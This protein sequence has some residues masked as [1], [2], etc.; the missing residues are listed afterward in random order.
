MTLPDHPELSIL[1]VVDSDALSAFIPALATLLRREFSAQVKLEVVSNGSGSDAAPLATLLSLEKMIVRRNRPCWA[2]RIAKADIHD[3]LETRSNQSFS[4]VIDLTKGT[5]KHAQ[6]V[7]RPLYNG[8][9]GEPAL[10]SSLLFLG[11][12]KISISVQREAS[13]QPAIICGGTASLESA[14]GIG[15]AMEAV[16]SRTTMLLV[17][18]IRGE[19]Q[20][21]GSQACDLQDAAEAP[22][23]S[24]GATLRYGASALAAAAA[25]AAYSLCCHRPHWRVGWR[26]SNISN[27]VWASRSLGGATWNILKDPID[28]FY[29]DPFPV[30][31]RGRDY[32]FFEDLDHKTQKGIISVV[33]FDA[34]GRPGPPI[35]VLEEP[36]HLS[37]PFI[38]EAD[39]EIWMI[40]EASLSGQ[41]TAYRAIEFPWRWEKHATLVS[42]V[43]AGDATIVAHND[44]LWMF[45]V[46]RQGIG[47][48]SD[49]LAMW[50]SGH[51]FGQWQPHPANPVLIDDREARP[52][53]AMVRRNGQLLRPVQDCRSGYGAALGL[54][55]VTKLDDEG[56]AQIVET[57]LAPGS[58]SWPGRKLHSLNGN[59]RLEVIDGSVP[60]PKM[61][62]ARHLVDRIYRPAT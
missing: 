44:R 34:E 9:A 54:A 3:L 38:I 5:Q 24:T 13:A 33:E 45:A 19:L 30:F 11:T 32:I 40:P 35:P 43:E 61:P 60:R 18:A 39:G 22:L 2:D 20:K 48:Y 28:H 46:I 26:F 50:S 21:T 53:G 31:W 16:W 57:R 52:A 1:I 14:A 25:N 23:I 15:G 47:G 59:G 4:F 56:F 42:D 49:A 12:P 10:A 51:L 8:A 62:L 37:Y 17:K 58:S 36:W 41:I 27:D 7:W 55:R 29:A 6:P